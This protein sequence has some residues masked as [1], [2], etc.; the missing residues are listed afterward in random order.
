MKTTNKMNAHYLNGSLGIVETALKHKEGCY[1]DECNDSN[2]QTCKQA[3]V[4]LLAVH[5]D[6][7]MGQTG[8]QGSV[9]RPSLADLHPYILVHPV[10]YACS[11]DTEDR[12]F[13]GS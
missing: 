12:E 4:S 11:N 2:Q 3:L 1:S 10:Q 5:A 8:G 13:G 6:C 9:A 7:P